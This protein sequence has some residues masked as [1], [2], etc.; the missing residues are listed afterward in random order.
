LINS[1]AAPGRD[2]PDG[3]AVVRRWPSADGQ[4]SLGPA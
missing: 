2:G 1:E 3:Q 4:A